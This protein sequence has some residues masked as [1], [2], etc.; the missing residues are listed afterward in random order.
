MPYTA[1][2]TW[3]VGEILTAANMNAQVRDNGLLGPEALATADGEVWIA[4]GAN[5]GEMVA[6][7]NSSNFL[8]HEFGGNEGDFSAIT[9]NE[10]LGGASAG[11]LEIKAPPSQAEAEA[12]TNTRFSLWSSERVKQAIAALATGATVTGTYTGDGNTSFA[13]TSGLGS[14]SQVK[15]VMIHRRQTTAANTNNKDVI[16]TSDTM[17]DDNAAGMAINLDNGGTQS[18]YVINTII[19]LGSDGTFT[20]DDA[21]GD[22]DPNQLNTVYNFI[23]WG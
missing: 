2:K 5:A 21:G 10:V 8:T 17:V 4:T 23:A 1:Y 9:T 12:G 13:I 18:E 19:A 15:F 6:I 7:L 11:V 22:A 14:S 20:V 16:W 3:T